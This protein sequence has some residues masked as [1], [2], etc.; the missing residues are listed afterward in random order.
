MSPQ[1]PG[2]YCSATSKRTGKPCR[3]RA[4][5]GT[6]HV[7]AGLCSHHGGN[8]PGGRIQAGRV[9]AG[10]FAAKHAVPL[11]GADAVEQLQDALERSAGRVVWLRI[12][13]EDLEPA[14]LVRGT[15]LVR[16]TEE[17]PAGP[18]PGPG[19]VVTL[20]EAKPGK[21]M[22]WRLLME[23]ED[24]LRS[25]ARD[26]AHVKAVMT[27]LEGPGAADVEREAE[28]IVAQV[29]DLA[30]VLRRQADLAVRPATGRARQA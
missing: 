18:R 9:I 15:T 30:P 26:L 19:S 29:L 16:R 25:I 13:V 12:Q 3:A 2:W 4:G 24:R 8:S 17:T 1:D 5:R 21:H 7:G 14:D 23:E 20:T 27:R 22:W 10:R 28:E 6:E 11:R